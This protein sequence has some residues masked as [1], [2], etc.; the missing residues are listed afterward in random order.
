MVP[1][2]LYSDSNS[3]QFVSDTGSKAE[4]DTNMLGYFLV[5]RIRIWIL[6]LLVFLPLTYYLYILHGRFGNFFVRKYCISLFGLVWSG[7]ILK[8]DWSGSF[9]GGVR[10]ER[11]RIRSIHNRPWHWRFKKIGPW[12]SSSIQ[13]LSFPPSTAK[14]LVNSTKSYLRHTTY[15]CAYKYR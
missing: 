2:R 13:S 9:K 4:H 12:L 14:Y 1:N 7:S 8:P 15:Q 3:Y 11:R 5:I 10:R 6:N